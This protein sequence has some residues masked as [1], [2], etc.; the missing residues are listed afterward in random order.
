MNTMQENLPMREVLW[1]KMLQQ[2]LVEGD[3]PQRIEL[4]KPLK[5]AWY[6]RVMLGFAG[7]LGALFLMGFVFLGLAS[8]ID[9]ALVSIVIG[10]GLCGAAY[11]IFHFHANKDFMTQFALALSLAGQGF[12][13]VGLFR[14]FGGERPGLFFVLVMFEI[15]L[16]AVI[17][18]CRQEKKLRMHLNI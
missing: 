4:D 8:I 7:W 17:N 6:L 5:Q 10:L 1:Q 3:I 14:E 9:H 16:I 18:N 15:A 12:V 13:V 2:H 11:A